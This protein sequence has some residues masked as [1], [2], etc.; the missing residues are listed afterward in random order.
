VADDQDGQ[1]SGSGVVAEGASSLEK[2]YGINEAAEL[3]QSAGYQVT[4]EWLRRHYRSMPHARFGRSVYFTERM[5]QQYIDA[6]V[7]KAEALKPKAGDMSW[8]RPVSRRKQ[9]D[10][11]PAPWAV[12]SAE[13]TGRPRTPPGKR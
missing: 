6:Q 4:A 9:P 12:D 7:V 10:H 3:L 2:G 5:L 13:G 8:L 1:L 11:M